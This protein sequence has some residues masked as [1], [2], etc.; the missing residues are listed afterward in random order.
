MERKAI[1]IGATGLVGSFVVS[2]LEAA[3]NY[4]EIHLFVRRPYE[5]S[6]PRTQAHIVNFNQLEVAAELFHADDLFCCLGTTIKI[7]KTKEAFYKVDFTYVYESAKLA[8][9]NGVSNF[10][11][12]SSLGASPASP[13]Y[14]S[15]VKGKMENAVKKLPFKSIQIFRPSLLTG[16]R[17][18]KR[19]GEQASEVALGLFGGLLVGSL[20]KY[21][22]IAAEDVARAM[23]AGAKSGREGAHIY[24]SD[25]IQSMANK[26]R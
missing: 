14:Y 4:S 12:V 1:V 17:K 9:A 15:K 2:Q 3:N 11:I 26:A 21:R 23:I 25:R 10:L 20:R 16:P 13:V 18:V 7:A 19:F 5:T 6:H 8:A 22:A 24:L